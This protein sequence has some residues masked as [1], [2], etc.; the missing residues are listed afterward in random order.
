[1]VT[2]LQLVLA[3]AALGNG[4]RGVEALARS[5]ADSVERERPGSLLTIL[6][7]GWGLRK[8]PDARYGTTV[9]ELAGV[10]RSRRWHRPE[11]WAQVRVAQTL[12]PRRNHVARRITTADAV[13]DLSAGDSFTDLYGPARLATVSAPKHAAVRAGRPL[14]LLPQTYGP[15]TTAVGRHHAERLVRSAALAYARD[16]WSFAQLCELAGPDA[17]ATRIR[18]GVDVAFA[19]EPRRP[20]PEVSDRLDE[21]TQGLTAGINVSGLLHDA[22]GQ[23]RFGL[24]GNYLD[25]MMALV[26]RLLADGAHVVFVPH[27]H[28]VNGV[29]E[30][31][32]AAIDAIRARL[33]PTEATRVTLLSPGL[34]AAELKWCIS[35]LDWFA[36]SRMHATIAALSTLTPAAAFAYSDK[37]RG[38]FETCGMGR[39]VV[40]AR[41][42][43]GQ[44]A[45]EQLL[46]LFRRR[47]TTRRELAASAPVTIEGARLQL[48]AVLDA[49]A[50]WRDHAHPV[51]SIA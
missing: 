46:D 9:V 19:L 21:V 23:A 15:F 34:D 8:M 44:P 27:V 35:Q 29:G 12:A 30:S 20:C 48:T 1:M 51:G 10:R 25:T 4:N 47:E 24:V 38:V 28:E 39:H 17:D 42:V 6:D 14:V 18:Q 36:G 7:D 5:V 16:A 50:Q 3:G 32:I 22:A 41:T 45:V 2:G 37:T 43:A 26:R 31:D 13:L 40:D 11:S 33:E 49:V